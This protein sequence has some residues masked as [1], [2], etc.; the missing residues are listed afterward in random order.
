[1]PSINES[2]KIICIGRNYIDHAKE[3]NNPVPDKP[4]FF[5]K[6]DTALLRNNWP[7]YIPEFTSEVHYETE[8]VVKIK[9]QGKYIAKKFA[10]R[11]YDEIGLGIDF[12]AR[13]LQK[14]AKNKGLPWEISKAF[15]H[16]AAI[17]EFIPLVNF[18]NIQDIPF[19]MYLNDTLVQ[20]A[21]TKDMVFSVDE[22]IT[23][24]SQFITFKIGDLIY[25]GTPS[26][27]GK[28]N[29][30]DRLKGYI[31]DRIMFDIKIK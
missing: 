28:V 27:V 12:T 26:G 14:E 7:F 13:D 1:M 19:R 29:P 17:S 11:Y 8:I 16:S 2:M 10:Q 20:E 5:I 9:K 24:V 3:L 21:N 22:L 15:D 18:K 23:Y 30:G 6:P 31:N 25:T 4:V